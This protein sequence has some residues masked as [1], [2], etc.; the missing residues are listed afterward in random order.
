MQ[1]G[2]QLSYSAFMS[3]RDGPKGRTRNPG[4]RM[5]APLWIPGSR[6][7]F[8]IG[9]RFARTRWRVPR[10]DRREECAPE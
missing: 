8:I 1:E 7:E 4:P 6:A 2:P 5:S 9:P 10:N 3:F